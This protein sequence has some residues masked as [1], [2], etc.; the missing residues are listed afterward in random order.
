V[1]PGETLI[2]RLATGQIESTVQD[3]RQLRLFE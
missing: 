3:A 2:T 1:K